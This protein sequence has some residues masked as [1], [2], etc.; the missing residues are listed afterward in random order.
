[1]S[2][3]LGNTSYVWYLYGNVDTFWCP[4]FYIL[5]QDHTSPCSTVKLLSPLNVTQPEMHYNHFS[6]RCLGNTSSVWF[7]ICAYTVGLHFSA[8]QVF[9]L[10][11]FAQQC[12]VLKNETMLWNI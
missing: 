7:Y 10:Y 3:M 1:M 5:C 6:L 4:C 2:L 11:I 8:Q 12:L 9:P